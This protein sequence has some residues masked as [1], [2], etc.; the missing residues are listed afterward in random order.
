MADQQP[1]DRQPWWRDAVIYQI[2][3]RSW[4]DS[5]GDG[6]GDLPGITA[7]LAHV[8]ALGADAIW[9]SPFYTSPQNDAGY[10]VADYRDID[11]RFGTLA[12]ADALVER[13]HELG[14]R[15][16]FDLVPNHSS[17]EHPWFQAALAAPPGSP[18]RARYVFRE[19]RGESG[20]LPPNN[21]ESNFGGPAWTRVTEA[22]GR[23]GQWYLHLFDATQPDFDW[24]NPEVADEMESVI[25]FWLD[26][27]VDGFRIDVAHGLVKVPGLPDVPHDA[28]ALRTERTGALPMWDQPGVHDIYRR[29]RSVT[30]SYAVPGADADRILC[31]EAWVWPT[32]A[33]ADY[34]RPDEL[35]QTFNFGFLTTPWIAAE[36]R[37]EIAASL[38]AVAEVGAPQTWVL[39]NHDVVR[40]ASRL[41]YD[42]V[43]GA[44]HMGGIGPDDPQPDA[45]AGLRRAR[46]A[47]TV[48]LALPGSAYLYQG[49]ELGLPEATELPDEVR[50][51]PHWLRSG[52][53]DLGRDGC[54]VPVPWEADAPSYGFGP[55]DN[56]WLPQP[57]AYGDL[58]VDRQDG[59]AGSTLELYRTLLRV[60][61]DL[62][63]GVGDLTWL[64]LGEDVLAFEIG[65]PGDDSVRVVANLGDAP[66]PL[67]EGEVLVAS[68]VIDGGRLPV[69]AAAWIR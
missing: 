22:D 66:V 43:P 6:L 69:D 36:L 29:W 55:N 65:T 37:A 27:G 57:A 32:Q 20:E 15:V 39:S 68:A 26:R 46:A 1:V 23:P 44:L 54:R 58:A 16:L 7:R 34:V 18:E 14:L 38:M 59:V 5:D 33:L 50:Q 24:S 40:H 47:T 2:Y 56:A 41:G 17:S 21:W 53:T 52:G 25:R 28:A 19:G 62:R 31:G 4:S 45:E 30:D 63:L 64:D 9:I 67:L 11:P 60:R 61:R 51:C 42:P 49:E 3:P 8:A 12:D 48:M 10:D 35:H 13:A